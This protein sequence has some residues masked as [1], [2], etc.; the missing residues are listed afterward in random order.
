VHLVEELEE[1]F[2]CDFRRVVDHLK[3]LGVCDICE[4]CFHG[5]GDGMVRHTSS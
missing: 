2:I 3:G 5:T 1:L 4:L